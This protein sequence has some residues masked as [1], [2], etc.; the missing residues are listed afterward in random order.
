MVWKKGLTVARQIKKRVY[1]N[2][3][4][5]NLSMV[6]VAVKSDKN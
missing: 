2:G 5:D 6:I 4:K 3:A 1:Q